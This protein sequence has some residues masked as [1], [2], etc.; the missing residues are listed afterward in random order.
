MD[1]D[2]EETS[3]LMKDMFVKVTAQEI[4]LRV[5]VKALEKNKPGTQELIVRSIRNAAQ[6][7]AKKPE[8]ADLTAELSH[9]A[10]IFEQ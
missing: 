4:V 6:Q 7:T 2:F 3:D 8:M 1:Q 5:L 10:M 9:I